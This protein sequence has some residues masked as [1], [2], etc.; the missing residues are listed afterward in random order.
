MQGV[1]LAAQL[2]NIY[3]QLNKSL[4]DGKLPEGTVLKV[5]HKTYNGHYRPGK[6]DE[7]KEQEECDEIEINEKLLS[8][9]S[10]ER[11]LIVLLHQMLHQW[12][13]YH[14]KESPSDSYHDKEYVEKARSIGLTID[15]PGQKI[16]ESIN[17]NGKFMQVIK[18]L[19]F[20]LTILPRNVKSQSDKER[21]SKGKEKYTCPSCG[22]NLWAKTGASNIC[23]S[24]NG[25]IKQMIEQFE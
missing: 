7:T 23:C 10:K 4:F 8:N 12:Q 21:K 15:K 17:S 1:T 22:F 18:N 6:W 14:G 11:W 16:K 24:C 5:A 2:F 20:E 19:N 9:S 13:Y 3:N 25:T